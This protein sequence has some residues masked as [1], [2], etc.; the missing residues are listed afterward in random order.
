ME[1]TTTLFA[2]QSRINELENA[3]EVSGRQL[4]SEKASRA[5]VELQLSTLQAQHAEKDLHE[6]ILDPPLVDDL[7]AQLAA[8]QAKCTALEQE[9][10]RLRRM[11]ELLIQFETSADEAAR[12]NVELEAAAREGERSRSELVDK[13][14]ASARRLA[15]EEAALVA[16]QG[17]KDASESTAQTHA[18]EMAEEVRTAQQ[19]SATLQEELKEAREKL[20]QQETELEQMAVHRSGFVESTNAM[21]AQLTD[22]KTRNGELSGEVEA[23]QDVNQALKK[24]RALVIQALTRLGLGDVKEAVL[25]GDISKLAAATPQDGAAAGEAMETDRDAGARALVSLG[26]PSRRKCNC[27]RLNV[28]ASHRDWCKASP[29]NRAPPTEA[30]VSAPGAKKAKV[31]KAER[32]TMPSAPTLKLYLDGL[33]IMFDA[34]DSDFENKLYELRCL[35]HLPAKSSPGEP[36]TLTLGHFHEILKLNGHDDRLEQ[37]DGTFM[38]PRE[39]MLAHVKRSFDKVEEPNANAIYQELFR[40][41]INEKFNGTRRHELPQ[42]DL[43]LGKTIMPIVLAIDPRRHAE[44]VRDMSDDDA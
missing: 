17:E 26:A 28:K 8:A 5:A 23:L 10:E 18:M 40:W 27:D 34:V 9:V 2:L 32:P 12:K 20:A 11:S 21:H 3:L 39:M 16:L 1:G 24:Q 35:G 19:R 7:R 22:Q 38:T 33:L 41:L 42:W 6:F 25:G 14:A 44:M 30:C 43:Q 31:T 36:S 29:K 13:L 4:A 15:Q 37:P